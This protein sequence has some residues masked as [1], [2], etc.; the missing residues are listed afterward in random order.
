L[1]EGRDDIIESGSQGSPRDDSKAMLS[2]EKIEK[3][4]QIVY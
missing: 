4:A 3:V 2:Q 1:E